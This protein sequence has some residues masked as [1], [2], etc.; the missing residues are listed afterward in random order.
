LAA[1]A[2]RSDLGLTPESRVLVILSEQ[3]S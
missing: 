2:F 3:A 1:G